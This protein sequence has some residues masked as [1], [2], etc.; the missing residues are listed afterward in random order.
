MTKDIEI[1]FIDIDGTLTNNKGIITDYTKTV[2]KTLT[3]KGIYVIM[4]SGRA[5][6]DLI[7]KSKI[8][9]ASPIIISSN[10]TL[11]FD[12]KK[13]IKIYESKI[14]FK[15]L[16]EIWDF[17][18]ENNIDLTFNSIYKRFKT[19]NSRKDATIISNLLKVN[20][21]V[22]QIVAEANSYEAINLL[23]NFIDKFNSLKY[24]FPIS[25]HDTS[26]NV[27]YELDIYNDKNEKGNAIRI[28]LDYLNINK[29]FSMG[30][31]DGINDFSMFNVCKYKVAM[32]NGNKKLKEKADFVTKFNND[33]DGVAKFI[34]N[35]YKDFMPLL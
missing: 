32:V 7:E 35:F 31:G 16:E 6:N 19:A 22:T 8:A 27:Y 4:C 24:G 29:N 12:Y 23:M 33:E 15:L 14:D 17:S 28:L 3:K 18:L 26:N 21:N 11:I 10:G 9:N 30:I 34:K 25:Q 5:N 1:I 2:I 20:E 13:D